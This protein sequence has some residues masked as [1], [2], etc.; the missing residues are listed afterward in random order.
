LNLV[1]TDALT[2][3][4][5][6]RFDTVDRFQGRAKPKFRLAGKPFFE[7]HWLACEVLVSRIH[8]NLGGSEHS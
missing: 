8:L 7:K 3:I 6:P 5:E 1:R 2:S 4:D